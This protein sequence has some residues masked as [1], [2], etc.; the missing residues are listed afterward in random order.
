MENRNSNSEKEREENWERHF[1][2]VI[3]DTL[4]RLEGERE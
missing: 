3:R 1:E 4:E 2:R